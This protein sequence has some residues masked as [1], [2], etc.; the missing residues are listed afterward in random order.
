M[1]SEKK[2]V[3]QHNALT[4]AR[5]E[6]SA[7]EMD[8][9][10]CLLSK[11]NSNKGRKY[12]IYVTDIENQTGRKWNYQQLRKATYKMNSRVYEIRNKN[13]LQ[14]SLL[15]SSEYI[16]G[17]GAIELEISDKVKPYLLDLKEHFTSFKLHA[18]FKLTSTYAKRI[19]QIASQWK[20][21]GV[22]NYTIEEL[23]IMLHLKDPEGIKPERY[24]QIGDF[25]KKVLNIAKKQINAHTELHIDYE[26]QK[27]G[28]AYH[29]VTFYV[30]PQGQKIKPVD[31]KKDDKNHRIIEIAKEL[32]INRK[33][34]IQKIVEDE[35]IQKI[36]RKY[37]NDIKLGNYSEVRNKAAYFI[38]MMEN[39]K[40]DQNGTD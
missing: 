7:C 22:V 39:H 14:F 26:L 5:Y 23:K 20:K 29:S 30:K 40:K 6:M 35:G 2:E 1:E 24:N 13:L 27:Q 18:A 33:D 36:L 34:I 8:I 12:T 21:K 10:F 3:R 31:F 16:T 37:A 19:Y 4:T 38:K 11:I 32:D 25:K 28:R 15:A 9:M 17:T